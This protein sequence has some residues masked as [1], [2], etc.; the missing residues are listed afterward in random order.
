LA[1]QTIRGVVIDRKITQG[2]RSDWGNAWM[3]RFWSV[4]QTCQ[5]QGRNVMEFLQ[6][7]TK[8]FFDKI[9]APTLLKEA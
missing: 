1:E 7:C 4:L 6:E 5:Q 3:E 2:S 9:P 8:N